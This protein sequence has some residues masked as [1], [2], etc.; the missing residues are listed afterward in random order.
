MSQPIIILDKG[1][2]DYATIWH[3]MRAFT[4]Q[5]NEQTTDE[6]WLLEH[7]PVFTQ[8]QAGKAEHIL[9]ADPHIPLIQTDRGGQVTYHGPGQLMAYF[10]LNIKRRDLAVRQLV[11]QLEQIVLTLLNRYQLQ[12]HSNAKAPGVYINEAKICSLGLRIRKGCSYH[13]LSLNVKMDLTPFDDINPCGY[14]GLIMTQLADYYPDITMAE[15]K[16]KLR[17][18]LLQQFTLD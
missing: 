1:I 2:A 12:G 3:A 14:E 4:E 5:R 18:I 7:P 17:D 6:I 11:N 15:V 16:A 8:G 9:R 13:G 10:L